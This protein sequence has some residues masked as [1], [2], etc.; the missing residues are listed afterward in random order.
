MSHKIFAKGVLA[1]AAGCGAVL[2]GVA[3]P[4]SA[5]PAPPAQPGCSAGDMA[6]VMSGVANA[7]GDYLLANPQVNDFFTSLKDLPKE[8]KKES[9]RTYLDANP[10]VKADLEGIRQPAKDF[11]NRCGGGHG[12]HHS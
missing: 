4:V 8:Q 11:K 1:A 9:M 5:Q 7:K 2:I 6:K 10:Q 3:A 12:D